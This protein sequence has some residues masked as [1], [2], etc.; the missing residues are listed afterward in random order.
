MAFVRVEQRNARLAAPVRLESVNGREGP[1]SKGTVILISNARRGTGEGREEE[2]TSILWTLWGKQADNAA[3]YLSKG[4]RVNVIGRLQNNNYSDAQGATVYGL[5][6][7]C[8]EIDYLDSR[9]EAEARRASQV[10]AASGSAG[11]T[12]VS[13]PGDKGSRAYG[14]TDV[15]F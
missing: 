1:V 4:S 12:G 11:A 15:P 6:F 3:Q 14:D 8:E 7:T 10:A 9:T 13:R 2:A 5:N